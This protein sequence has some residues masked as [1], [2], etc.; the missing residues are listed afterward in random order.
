[1]NIKICPEVCNLVGLWKSLFAFIDN[2]DSLISRI[3][4]R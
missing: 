4:L 3:R 2:Q 1:M